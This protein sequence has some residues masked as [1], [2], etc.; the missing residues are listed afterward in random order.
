[1]SDA[2]GGI[3]DDM[4]GTVTDASSFFQNALGSAVARGIAGGAKPQNDVSKLFEADRLS[5]M[6]NVPDNVR[7]SPAN[8]SKFKAAES[9]NFE[10]VEQSWLQRL[11]RFSQ[12]DEG[13]QAGK[14]NEGTPR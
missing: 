6:D 7:Y 5:K 4:R 2:F 13:L 12:I 11:H 8:D 10:N 14:V 1:M 9:V 3:L